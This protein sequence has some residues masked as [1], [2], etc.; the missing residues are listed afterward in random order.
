MVRRDV[1]GVLERVPH[2]GPERPAG[3]RPLCEDR[4]PLPLPVE[5]LGRDVVGLVDQPTQGGRAA[6]DRLGVD[7]IVVL[8]VVGVALVVTATLAAVTD[9]A[10]VDHLR[11]AGHF[12]GVGGVTEVGDF[13]F[14]LGP[15]EPFRVLAVRVVA[16]HAEGLL[17]HL[18]GMGDRCAAELPT[19]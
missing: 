8:D 4:L 1:P 7:I 5:D 19:A 11:R 16:R 17:T 6:V 15:V 2:R 18:L 13:V 9:G 3:P 14:V 10:E 12:A